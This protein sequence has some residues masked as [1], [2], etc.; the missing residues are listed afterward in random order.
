MGAS[1]PLHGVVSPTPEHAYKRPSLL[2]WTGSLDRNSKVLYHL[3]AV[4]KDPSFFI[5]PASTF[6]SCIIPSGLSFCASSWPRPRSQTPIQLP[7]ESTFQGSWLFEP[8][9]TFVSA[10]SLTARS[11]SAIVE[12]APGAQPSDYPYGTPHVNEPQYLNWYPND[13]GQ[14]KADAGKIHNGYADMINMVYFAW[15]E[16]D[17]NSNTF[18][19]WFDQGDADNVKKV[20]EKI[21][22]PKGVGQANPLMTQWVCQ[23]DDQFNRC[24]GTRR[25]WSASNRGYFH[26]CPLGLQQPNIGDLKCSDLDG[27][28]SRKMASVAF[29]MMHEAT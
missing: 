20:L 3:R 1:S 29:T 7:S 4:S 5:I 27:Y 26:M 10:P 6:L 13:N 21:L 15:V 2:L 14:Q 24:T 16:A 11:N 12:R 18:K 19:R 23:Q 28:P 8:P 17:K 25:A 9:L 22:D